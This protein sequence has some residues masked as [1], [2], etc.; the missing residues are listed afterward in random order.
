M[1]N[2]NKRIKEDIQKFSFL[3]T[4]NFRL[5]KI[6]HFDNEIFYLKKK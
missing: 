6:I 4:L 2:K 5:I 3:L 1:N